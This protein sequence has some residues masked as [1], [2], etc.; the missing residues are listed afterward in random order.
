MRLEAFREVGKSEFVDVPK[1]IAEL[2][3]TNNSLNIQV[4]R[5]LN[6]VGEE[7]ESK[8]VS[9]T[10]RNTF[11]EVSGLNEAGF[12]DLLGRKVRLF[13]FLKKDI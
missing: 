8:S 5:A 4:N 10:L 11:G 6:H 1:L 12:F 9:T 3:V 2:F 13:K 7:S